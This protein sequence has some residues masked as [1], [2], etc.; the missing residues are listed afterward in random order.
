MF[1][2][3]GVGKTVLIMELIRGTVEKYAGLSVFAGIADAGSLSRTLFVCLSMIEAMTILRDPR[4]I[5]ISGGAY[6]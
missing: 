2:G 5:T 6:R 1:G 4:S 3:A